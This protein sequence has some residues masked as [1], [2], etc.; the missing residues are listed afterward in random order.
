M[1]RENK[2]KRMLKEQKNVIGTFVKTSD[3]AVVEVLGY[4]GFDFI[5][6][7]NEHTAMNIEST[8]NLIRAAN[9]SGTAPVVRVRENRPAEILQALDAGALGVQ[10]PQ[11]NTKEEAVQVV[12]SVKYAPLGKRGYAASQRSAMYGLM[13][14][15]EYAERSNEET[16]ISCYCETAEAIRN[17]DQ[18]LQVEPIDVIFIGPF[19]LSQALGVLGQPNHPKV[20]K[21]IDEITEKVRAANKAA[22]IIASNAGQAEEWIQKGI[23]Y[24]SLSSDLGMISALGKQYLQSL[25]K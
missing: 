23:Q 13:D 12:A 1:I 22:G 21:A 25:R 3:P 5:I 15:V 11:V 18:I 16:L 7:D 17:L 4:A 19:D 2:V 8:V 9:L 14:P 24:I 20:L 10:V 6:I